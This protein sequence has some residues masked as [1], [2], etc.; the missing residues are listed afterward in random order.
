[1]T[2]SFEEPTGF[3]RSPSCFKKGRGKVFVNNLSSNPW[4]KL[5]KSFDERKFYISSKFQTN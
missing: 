3:E 5:K 2:Q 4:E 1:M